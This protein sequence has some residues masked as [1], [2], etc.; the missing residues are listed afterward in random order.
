MKTAITLA[1]MLLALAC[2]SGDSNVNQQ[3]PSQGPG[4]NT[5]VGQEDLAPD[6]TLQD[7]NGNPVRLSE[8]R[9]KTPVVLV[10]YRGYW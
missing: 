1:I 9:G 10:F 8:A 4:G 6:F 5:P 7:H 2:A 3:S